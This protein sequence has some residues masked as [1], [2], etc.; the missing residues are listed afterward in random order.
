MPRRRAPYE[1]YDD[2]A[3]ITIGR[4]GSEGSDIK[5]S[6][7]DGHSDKTEHFLELDDN[8]EALIK[9]A[10]QHF[11]KVIVLINSANTMELGE[12]NAPKTADNL[13]VDAILQIGHPG[14]TARRHWAESERHGIPFG[15]DGGY[16]DERFSPRTPRMQTFSSMT[17]NGEGWEQQSLQ[18]RRHGERKL[19]HR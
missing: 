3:I 11:N 9:Y 17:Q 18:S 1:R 8:E 10:K 7:V 2:A 16:L 14:T 4:S 13:G 19:S 5:I 15:Q 6:N 12:L